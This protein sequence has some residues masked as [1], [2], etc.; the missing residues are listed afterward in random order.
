M[1][2]LLPAQW[3]VISDDIRERWHSASF[4]SLK[5]KLALNLYWP[6][7]NIFGIKPCVCSLYSSLFYFAVQNK[8]ISFLHIAVQSGQDSR[9]KKLT[10]PRNTHPQLMFKPNL[11]A[12]ASNEVYNDLKNKENEVNELNWPKSAREFYDRFCKITTGLFDDNGRSKRNKRVFRQKQ[13][14]CKTLYFTSFASNF[15]GY[16]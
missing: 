11:Y 2:K 4:T 3:R 15:S 8:P 6:K 1:N 5:N 10:H 16:H 12:Y 14:L 13:P 7:D 9:L